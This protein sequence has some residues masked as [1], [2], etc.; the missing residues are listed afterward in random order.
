MNTAP[1]RP[2]DGDPGDEAFEAFLTTADDQLLEYVRSKTD[3]IR[4]MGALLRV[5]D[6]SASV[7]EDPYT[8]PVDRSV[9]KAVQRVRS[10]LGVHILLARLADVHDLAQRLSDTLA[11]ARLD[12]ALVH[13]LTD[14]LASVRDLVGDL[15]ID[16]GADPDVDRS[17]DRLLTNLDRICAHLADR[18][19]PLSRLDA[20]TLLSS[21][22]LDHDLELALRIKVGVM[23]PSLDVSGVNLARLDAFGAVSPAQAVQALDGVVWDDSTRWPGALTGIIAAQ[24]EPIDEGRYK[25]RAGIGRSSYAR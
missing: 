23:R 10:R 17:L 21:L 24:S 14:Q 9:E 1:P 16:A 19:P 3:P 8:G 20:L 7:P 2:P 4:A 13:D 11:H 22:D 15:G 12:S 18:N 5:L 25:V 6:G